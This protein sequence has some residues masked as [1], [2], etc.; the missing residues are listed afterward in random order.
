M[1]FVFIPGAGGDGWYWHLLEPLLAEHGHGFVAPDLPAEDEQ[2]GLDAYA[3][4][5]CAAAGDGRGGVVVAQSMGALTAPLVVER[6]QAEA[7]VLVAPMILAPGERGGSWWTT[8]GQ[9][10]AQREHDLAE[11]RDPDAPFDPVELFLHDLPEDVLQALLAR[12]EP[13][14]SSA[15][16]ADPWP[17]AAWPDVPTRVIAGR[18]DRLLP[19]GFLQE[20][21][22]ERLGVEPDVVDTGHLPALV[23]PDQVAEVLLQTTRP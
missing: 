9:T 12:D 16:F 7:L 11:G 4:V 14:Q 3:D 18:H 1:R 17:V 23:R 21:S 8:S 10:A 5:V 13:D 19:L 22:R 20:L 2:A 6:L 15:P